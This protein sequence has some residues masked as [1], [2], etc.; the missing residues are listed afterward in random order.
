[1]DDFFVY[2]SSLCSS[3]L[4]RCSSELHIAINGY[5]FLDPQFTVAAHLEASD[6]MTPRSMIDSIT[7]SGQKLEEIGCDRF[8]PLA[9]LLFFFLPSPFLS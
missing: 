8:F 4:W 6:V 2:S 7:S 3:S 5:P 9:F 1:M